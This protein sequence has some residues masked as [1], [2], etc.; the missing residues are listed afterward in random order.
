MCTAQGRLES[1]MSLCT[2][3]ARVLIRIPASKKWVRWQQKTLNK[4]PICAI[5]PQKVGGTSGFGIGLDGARWDNGTQIYSRHESR[6]E[7]WCWS[8]PSVKPN[9]SYGSSI[10][11]GFW[12]GNQLQT[13]QLCSIF[14]Q[15]GGFSK[16]LNVYMRTGCFTSF[17]TAEV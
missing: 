16:L 9:C 1:G 5:T 6:W 2:W 12:I 8:W 10:L 13:W 14:L 17:P 4:T 3:W 7:Q 11:P 15:L